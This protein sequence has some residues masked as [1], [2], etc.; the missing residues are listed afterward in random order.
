[1]AAESREP[2]GAAGKAAGPS[3][4]APVAGSRRRR[5]G[6]RGVSR[7]VPLQAGYCTRVGLHWPGG[8]PY[9]TVPGP[10]WSA[11]MSPPVAPDYRASTSGAP[12]GRPQPGTHRSAP[13]TDATHGARKAESPGQ[14]SSPMVRPLGGD[15][16]EGASG[17]LTVGLHEL[18]DGGD[19]HRRHRDEDDHED[20]ASM[21]ISAISKFMKSHRQKS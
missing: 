18:R 11:P 19:E 2:A 10:S 14:S 7:P 20:H 4:S 6:R 5:P 8:Y 17:L 21:L 9:C 15:G 3:G 12:R 13:L 16:E 1:M